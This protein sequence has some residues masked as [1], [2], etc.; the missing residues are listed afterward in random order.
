[1]ILSEENSS[2]EEAADFEGSLPLE[3]S[4]PYLANM[5]IYEKLRG[6]G[7]I[8]EGNLVRNG[9]RVILYDGRSVT[10]IKPIS[11]FLEEE[12]V[13]GRQRN[14]YSALYTAKRW[15]NLKAFTMSIGTDTKY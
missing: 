14:R 5:T 1:M 8:G 4:L 7:K 2:Q 15:S 10:D 13:N 6:Q 9:W 3:E 12:T 11:G